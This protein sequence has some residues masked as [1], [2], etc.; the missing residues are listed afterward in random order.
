MVYSLAFYGVLLLG[1]IVALIFVALHLHFRLV[2][3][4]KSIRKTQETLIRLHTHVYSTSSKPKTPV[5]KA[6]K[7]K[8]ISG[9]MTVKGENG[10]EAT[11]IV[12]IR[13]TK[14]E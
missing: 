6:F 5:Y 14:I 13:P 4:R 3:I 2:D 9:P 7:P 10:A 1:T 8:V 11:A 12:T